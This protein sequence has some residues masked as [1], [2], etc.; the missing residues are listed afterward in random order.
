MKENHQPG[1]PHASSRDVSRGAQ[2]LRSLKQ[3]GILQGNIDRN[4]KGVPTSFVNNISIF[5]N[6]EELWLNLIGMQC[7]FQT[8]KSLPRSTGAL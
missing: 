7:A 8:Y 2:V 3:P 5:H 1:E 6:L 4:V